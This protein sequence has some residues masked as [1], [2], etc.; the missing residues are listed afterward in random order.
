[1]KETTARDTKLLMVLGSVKVIAL[2]SEPS[3]LYHRWTSWKVK[4]WK[5]KWNS[6]IQHSGNTDSD[7]AKPLFLPDS[8]GQ[9]QLSS[10]LINCTPENK[11]VVDPPGH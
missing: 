2:L 3:A 10:P 5:E 9:L 11:L 4:K 8:L 7:F 6:E 1:M